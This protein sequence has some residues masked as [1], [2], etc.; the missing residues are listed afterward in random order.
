MPLIMQDKRKPGAVQ[1]EPKDADSQTPITCWVFCRLGVCPHG[2]E[3]KEDVRVR[4]GRRVPWKAHSGV[5]PSSDPLGLCLSEARSKGR[6][7]PIVRP[8]P[9]VQRHSGC[10]GHRPSCLQP[11]PGAHWPCLRGQDPQACTPR[12]LDGGPGDLCLARA[13][14]FSHFPNFPGSAVSMPD[15]GAPS[16]C[17]NLGM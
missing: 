1:Q 12:E 13:T 3:R 10:H 7:C 11:L 16:S 17:L 8:G 14:P 2:G 15:S 9:G 6:F 5:G 4:T